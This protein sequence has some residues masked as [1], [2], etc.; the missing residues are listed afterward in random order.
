MLNY[1]YNKQL[2]TKSFETLLLKK[3]SI[4]NYKQCE[5]KLVNRTKLFFYEAFLENEI[6]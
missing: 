2:T 1:N 5:N 6:N 3:N 4:V